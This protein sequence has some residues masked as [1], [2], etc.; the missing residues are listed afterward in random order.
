MSEGSIALNIRRQKFA[1]HPHTSCVG[2]DGL[3]SFFPR[4]NPNA[5][6]IGSY[7]SRCFPGFEEIEID[8]KM[9]WR[10]PEQVAIPVMFGVLESVGV[11]VE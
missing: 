6:P 7:G 4:A 2:P 1:I 10:L 8:G 5:E 9:E 3:V 11:N